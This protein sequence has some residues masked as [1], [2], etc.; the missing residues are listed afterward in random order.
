MPVIGRD[1]LSLGVAN[2]FSAEREDRVQQYEDYSDY[3]IYFAQ[4]SFISL[5]EFIPTR[6]GYSRYRSSA[7]SQSPNGKW[8]S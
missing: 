5:L 3:Q 1:A 2:L 7:A 4:H 6:M 8:Q